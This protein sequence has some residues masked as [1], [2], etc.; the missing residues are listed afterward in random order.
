MAG[1]F[2]AIQQRSAEMVEATMTVFLV[3][4]S[5]FYSPST[6]LGVYQYRGDA[7]RRASIEIGDPFLDYVEIEEVE[8]Q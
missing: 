6:V 1:S 4:R 2:D 3:V 8:V 7:E 5:R